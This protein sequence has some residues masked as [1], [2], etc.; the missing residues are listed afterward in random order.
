MISL[1][2][3]FLESFAAEALKHMLKAAATVSRIN[4]SL[5]FMSVLVC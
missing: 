4:V 5:F 2:A 1:S 3:F